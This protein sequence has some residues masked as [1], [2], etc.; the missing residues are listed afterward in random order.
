MGNTC[1]PLNAF[2]TPPEI[3][4]SKLDCADCYSSR[5]NRHFENNRLNKIRQRS[6]I[7]VKDDA[8]KQG[9]N[10]EALEL[11]LDDLQDDD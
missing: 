11:L 6:I 10:Q 5:Y 3:G 4:D 2:C 9:I 7:Q 1:G 8:L